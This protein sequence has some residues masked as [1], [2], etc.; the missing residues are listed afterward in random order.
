MIRVVF[1][2]LTHIWT[3]LP[4]IICDDY[5]GHLYTDRRRSLAGRVEDCG[6]LG[7]RN[8]AVR[9]RRKPGRQGEW[10][11]DMDRLSEAGAGSKEPRTCRAVHG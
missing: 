5:K 6:G 10:E 8:R 9:S 3:P 2:Q 4:H 11:T 1:A 7:G